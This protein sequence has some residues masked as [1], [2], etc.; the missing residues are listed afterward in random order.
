MR[1]GPVSPLD[2]VPLAVEGMTGKV[3]QVACRV[4]FIYP[5]ALG[6]GSILIEPKTVV[7]GPREGS[8]AG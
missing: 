3:T 7:N 5:R 1:D 6:R 2:T 8:L 4:R